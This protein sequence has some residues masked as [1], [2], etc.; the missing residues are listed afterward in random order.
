MVKKR[1]KG[2]Q[3]RKS[4]REHLK[5]QKK[6]MN[7]NGEIK[8]NYDYKDK[9]D[10]TLFYG[11]ITKVCTGSMADVLLSEP[12]IQ[13]KGS[14]TLE[15]EEIK[16]IKRKN[17]SRGRKMLIDNVVIIQIPQYELD[18]D[19]PKGQILKILSNDN[20]RWLIKRGDLDDRF[21]VKE[22]NEYKETTIL[23]NV[24]NSFTFQEENVDEVDIDD[25]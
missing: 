8:V 22:E 5:R 6:L 7:A 24:D 4:H 3:G 10:P 25:I 16:V 18:K 13:K 12:L 17:R 23:D 14:S 15:I 20:V 19:K 9:D 2:N 21:V 11:K 1:G